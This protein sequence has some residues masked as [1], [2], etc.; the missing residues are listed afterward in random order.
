[1]GYLVLCA[2]LCRLE[3]LMEKYQVGRLVDLHAPVMSGCIDTSNADIAL[4]PVETVVSRW[5]G[6]LFWQLCC[7]PVSPQLPVLG[8]VS[9][10][11]LN[12][13]LL[14]G[15]FSNS[16]VVKTKVLLCRRFLPREVWTLG[17]PCE[18]KLGLIAPQH[19]VIV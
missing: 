14:D 1:M 3:W 17:F 7:A 16:R 11:S 9:R 5:V 15:W 12:S 10:C 19:K 4:S 8:L 18:R 2:C 13:V 6:G